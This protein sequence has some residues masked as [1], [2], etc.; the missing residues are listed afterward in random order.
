MPYLLPR[1]YIWYVIY[2]PEEQ[3]S[4][5]RKLLFLF[6]QIKL[7]MHNQFSLINQTIKGATT[8]KNLYR[9][10][11]ERVES[12]S[13]NPDI[14]MRKIKINSLKDILYIFIF[15][16][17]IVLFL[18]M[19][20]TFLDPKWIDSFFL[21]KLLF[22]EKKQQQKSIKILG[23]NYFTLNARP[24]SFESF[25]WNCVIGSCA[26]TP[27]ICDVVVVQFNFFLLHIACRCDIKQWID[28]YNGK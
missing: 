20:G 14:G 10:R 24:S 1:H 8:K 26:S 13:G 4:P 15:L 5:N 21:W 6:F 2:M 3:K 17:Y 18:F 19:G 25:P 22:K 11:K 16:L 23:K 27:D 9:H 12:L 28:R 7:N